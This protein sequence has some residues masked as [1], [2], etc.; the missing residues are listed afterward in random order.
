M[1]P[2]RRWN[3]IQQRGIFFDCGARHPMDS[4]ADKYRAIADECRLQAELSLSP[5]AK[6]F[7]AETAERWLV[8]ARE[9]DADDATSS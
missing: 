1:V 3:Q 9:A 4:R 6:V 5:A 7:W 2:Q 8:M